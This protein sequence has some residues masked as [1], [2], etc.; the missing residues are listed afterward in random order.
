MKKMVLFLVTVLS[1]LFFNSSGWGIPSSS[2][3]PDAKTAVNTISGLSVPFIENRGQIDK[4]VAYY[5]KTLGATLFVTQ[6]GEM[7]YGFPN[8]TLVE[9]ISGLTARPKGLLPSRASVSSFIGSNPE[10][11][12]KTLPTFSTVSLGTITPGVT[13]TLNAFGGKIE[14]IITVAPHASPSI[15]LKIDGPSS[16][17]LGHD[18]ELIA[19][20]EKGELTFSKPIAYQEING[21]KVSVL[22][23]YMLPHSSLTYTFALG[24]YDPS[25]ALI[26]DP[27]MQATYLGGSS[28]D[29]VHALAIGADGVYV[30]GETMSSN[31][32]GTT[33]GYQSDFGGGQIDAFV[34]LLSPDLKSLIQATYLGGSG[35]DRGNVLAIGTEGVY[36]GGYTGSSNFPGT[37]GG[38]QSTFAGG[39][40]DVFVSLLSPDLKS[41]TQSTYL[42]GS[43][44]E[45][46]CA[47]AIGPD[48]VY[49]GGEY[50][51][52]SNFP[53]TTGGAQS[54]WGGSDDVFVSL[55]SPD[56]KS[57]TQST[58]LG[59]VD[60]DHGHALAIGPDGVYVAGDTISSNF[61]GTTGGF[62][63][64]FAGNGAA[65]VA[66]LSPDLKSLTQSTYL[67]GSGNANGHALAIGPDGVYVSGGG[68]L[69]L[70][71]HHRGCPASIKRW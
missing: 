24:P 19:H 16:L 61:P 31:F 23:A 40:F 17:G 29:I 50:T 33:G 57:L 70:S 37:T 39:Q 52:S 67:G 30:A 27:L 41:L 64:T 15:T 48:G 34:A 65:F 62:Q 10:K 35:E 21:K 51:F 71:R 43:G 59:G 66:L 54:T 20:T 14:K 36:V 38:A 6:K 44:S 26:I 4:D 5:A 45:H 49:V 42:G 1:T 63:S 32:P 8:F 25:Y 46:P 7:V 56:L 53:G 69:Q 68:G 12:Q 13:V 9:R 22:V 3:L 58:Y 60:Y 47:L 2:Q 55:L 18:G 28:D 11:W